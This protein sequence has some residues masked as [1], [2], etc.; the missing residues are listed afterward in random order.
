MVGLSIAECLNWNIFF[1]CWVLNLI[2]HW[3][4]VHVLLMVED[5]CAL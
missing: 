2:V 5:L 4:C 1:L 3:D